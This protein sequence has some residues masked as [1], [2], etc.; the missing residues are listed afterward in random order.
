MKSIYKWTGAVPA[1]KRWWSFWLH[2]AVAGIVDLFSLVYKAGRLLS[3]L[4]LGDTILPSLITQYSCS[5]AVAGLS[6]FIYSINLLGPIPNCIHLHS[7]KEVSGAA[8]LHST[9]RSCHITL[10]SGRKFNMTYCVNSKCSLKSTTTSFVFLKYT[11][12][13]SDST[14]AIPCWYQ[15][16]F[17]P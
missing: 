10:K 16:R 14:W 3:E 6:L 7:S 11:L 13:L 1:P 15:Q 17:L 8:R 5:A 9:W 4:L 12:V 2:V